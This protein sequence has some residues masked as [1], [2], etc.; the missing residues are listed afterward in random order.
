MN[1]ISRAGLR[2]AGI[3]EETGDHLDLRPVCHIS[4]MGSIQ[5]QMGSAIRAMTGEILSKGLFIPGAAATKN[6]YNHLTLCIIFV[7]LTYIFLNSVH[8]WKVSETAL[9]KNI[10]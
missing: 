1:V 9:K 4:I 3:D 5:V 2:V 10:V 6:T 7:M 8:Q